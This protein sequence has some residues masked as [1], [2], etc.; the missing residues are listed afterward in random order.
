MNKNDFLEKYGPWALVT[1]ASSGI[2]AEFCRQLSGYGLN[3]VMIARRKSA[4]EEIA[5]N[6]VEKYS[7]EVKTIESDLSKDDFFAKLEPEISSLDIG[8]LINNA[9]FG[10]KGSFLS[11]SL[12]RELE[13]LNVNCRAPLELTHIIGQ[14]MLER[15]KGGIFFLSSVLGYSA[16]PYFANY[17]ASKAYNLFMGGALWSELKAAGIEDRP[18]QEIV[19]AKN[20][21][22]PD[23]E[24]A[25][26]ERAGV[27][28]VTWND[29]GYPARL[30]EI[31]DPPPVLFYKGTLLASDDRSVAIVGTRSPTTYGREAAA[32]LSRGLAQAGLTVVSGLALGI[33]GVAHRAALENGGRTIA[34][35]AGGL[36]GVYPKDHTALFGQVQEHGAV[37]S[38]QTLGVRPDSRS[39]P[40]RNRLISGMSLGSVVIEAAEGSGA[41]HTVYHALDQDREVFCVPGSIFSPASDF[42]N[43]M[44]KEGAKLVMGVTDILEELNMV[45]AAP[46]A[47]KSKKTLNALEN[48]PEQLSF[49]TADDDFPEEQALLSRLT[50]AP[51]HI[52]E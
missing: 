40:R 27:T 47:G 13:L 36:D 11:N 41:R 23:D 7:V 14:K 22:S 37:V 30:K 43:R 52:D 19:A 28:A 15:K 25:A 17:A 34:V 6:L 12:E 35:M 8:I 32:V 38:E 24:M 39:F 42:T 16:S 4:M 26:L 31:A 3:I 48:V 1:G 33:D 9:G 29:L 2:G 5:A 46:K 18:A 10:V 49:A 20:N 44:I 45:E 51:L 21:S 50:D